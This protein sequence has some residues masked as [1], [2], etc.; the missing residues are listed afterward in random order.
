VVRQFSVAAIAILSAL[1]FAAPSQALSCLRPTP[2]RSFAQF[3]DAPE[4]YQVWS[5]R[6]I[7]TNPIPQ[8][9]GYVDP[10]SGTKP[11]P[12]LY[13][14]RGRM[15]GPQGAF[16]PIRSFRVKVAPQCAGPWC[17][18]YPSGG[19]EAVGFFER[20]PTGARTF[21]PLPCGGASFS[22]TID[23]IDR[24]AACF[25]SGACN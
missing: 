7:Q 15:V 6:W 23:T 24:I 20:P 17:A 3:H 5:G 25:T 8:T 21:E 1:T 19:E 9:E 11:E 13:R 18:Q 12:V 14:F 2:E 22:R 16:G 4:L 10:N